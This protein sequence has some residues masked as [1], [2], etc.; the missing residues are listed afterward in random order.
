MAPRVRWAV[1]WGMYREQIVWRCPYTH[2]T[3]RSKSYIVTQ[4]NH[5]MNYGYFFARPMLS[6]RRACALPPDRTN[7]IDIYLEDVRP[8]AERAKVPI[9]DIKV[10]NNNSDSSQEAAIK[11]IKVTPNQELGG[12]VRVY[13]SKGQQLEV[14]SQTGELTMQPTTELHM[15]EKPSLNYT[16]IYFSTKTKK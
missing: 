7:R 16:C 1:A 14:D 10:I 8:V 5:D 6:T 11:T 4:L 12:S 2:S 9:T 15:T 13:D 3:F